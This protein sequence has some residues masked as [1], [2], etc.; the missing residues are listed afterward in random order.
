[1]IDDALSRRAFLAASGSAFASAWLAADPD[2][3]RASLEHAARAVGRR[4]DWEF[5]TPE[6]AADVDAIAAQII[7]SDDLPG[8]REAGAVYFFDHALATWAEDQREAFSRGLDDL[9]RRTHGRSPEAH[10]FAALSPEQQIDLLHAVEHTPFFQMA[11]FATIAGTFANPSWG[12]NRD[13]AGW[14]ILG[15]EDRFVWQPPFGDYDA[16]PGAGR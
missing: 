16:D 7:P 9:N 14:R 13:K 6:Q 15:F 1:M 5:F 4:G 11:R 2:E 12:G 8:A 3:L 10:R